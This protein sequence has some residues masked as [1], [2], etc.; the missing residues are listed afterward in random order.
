MSS[1]F[2]LAVLL[3][4][5]NLDL[6]KTCIGGEGTT[7]L[8]WL[9]RKMML[10]SAARFATDSDSDSCESLEVL[11]TGAMDEDY[12]GKPLKPYSE[13]LAQCVRTCLE[14]G[15]DVHIPDQYNKTAVDYF[16]ELLHPDG[17]DGGGECGTSPQY[18][19]RI[20]KFFSRYSVLVSH[21]HHKRIVIEG[22][23]RFKMSP[24]MNLEVGYWSVTRPK[25]TFGACFEVIWK[26][27]GENSVSCHGGL[28]DKMCYNRYCDKDEYGIILPQYGHEC[29]EEKYFDWLRDGGDMTDTAMV[30]KVLRL[31]TTTV[32]TTRK[33]ETLR[34]AMRTASHRLRLTSWGMMGRAEWMQKLTVSMARHRSMSPSRRTMP[35]GLR[36]RAVN[37]RT[38]AGRK[39][40]RR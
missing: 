13:P 23:K 10:N 8:T 22:Q 12:M 27:E 4:Q 2:C 18:C 5:E 6:A 1:P 36:K 20:L 14:Y 31:L 35:P 24:E 29:W 32:T 34:K 7:I 9:L 11:L 40:A 39:R 15:A 16:T 17:G 37:R 19:I 21:D 26:E 38:K 25:E 3:S 30:K 33:T 28:L